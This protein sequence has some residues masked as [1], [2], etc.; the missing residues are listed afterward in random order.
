MKILKDSQKSELWN[1][2]AMLW[3]LNSNGIRHYVEI[4]FLH[5]VHNGFQASPP[6]FQDYQT[7]IKQGLHKVQYSSFPPEDVTGTSSYRFEYNFA[8][9]PKYL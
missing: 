6:A 1:S 8:R 5:M 4:A 9:F 7:S 3:N 2:A